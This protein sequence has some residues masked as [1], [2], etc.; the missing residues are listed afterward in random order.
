MRITLIVAAS[1]NDVI[2]VRGRLPWHLP[3]DFKHFKETTMGKPV[4]MGR[5]TWD[6]IG[7]PLPGRKNIVLTHRPEFDAPGATVVSSIDAAI[8]AAGDA[9]ELMVIGGGQLYQQ[10]IESADRIYLTHVNV[11][12]DGDAKFPPL[13]PQQ[14]SMSSCQQHAADD[15]HAFDY[16]FRV[17]DR[18]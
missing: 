13:D 10:F 9:D 16:E 11:H 2:G 4:L 12:V 5:L 7:K 8:G 14:W 6:S 3:N 18:R 1:T 15:R 17:Y